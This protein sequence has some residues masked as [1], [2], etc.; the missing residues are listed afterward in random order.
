MPTRTDKCERM[1]EH[2]HRGTHVHAHHS[3]PHTCLPACPDR[4]THGQMHGRTDTW[5]DA[6]T[7]GQTG[8]K[9]THAQ[10]SHFHACPK[11]DCMLA[12][13]RTRSRLA[14]A[15]TMPC[16]KW[17]CRL[18]K[19]RQVSV[20][21]R[22][23]AKVSMPRTMTSTFEGSSLNRPAPRLDDP[24]QSNAFSAQSKPVLLKQLKLAK[25][26]SGA[27]PTRVNGEWQGSNK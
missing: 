19:S 26:M 10:I 2:T 8:R 16:T 13:E 4:R 11:F 14:T 17:A 20:R 7:H 5:A 25:C 27:C 3:H 15:S 1:F 21:R 12:A 24:S 18:R 22:S 6:R 9:H 23:S